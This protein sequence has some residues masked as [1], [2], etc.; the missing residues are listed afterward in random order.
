MNFYDNNVAFASACRCQAHCVIQE[1]EPNCYQICNL[2]KLQ[3]MLTLDC[4]AESSKHII[5]FFIN[6]N[7]YSIDFY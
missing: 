1:V 5:T 2:R 3:I 6:A 4:H 7:Y